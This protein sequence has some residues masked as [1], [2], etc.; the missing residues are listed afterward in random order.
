[1]AASFIA[2]WEMSFPGICEAARLMGEG[3]ANMPD[4]L[5]AAIRNAEDNPAFKSV[6][7][8]G[9]PNWDGELELGRA[10]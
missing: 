9:L 1:M 8:G 3:G 5:C 6:G 2:T 4:A 10:L 7:F